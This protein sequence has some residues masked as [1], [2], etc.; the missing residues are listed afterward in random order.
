L[1]AEIAAS[2]T[3]R[4]TGGTR[5]SRAFVVGLALIALAGFSV[6]IGYALAGGGVR[7]SD[8]GGYYHVAAN[9][10]VDG[11]GFVN[12]WGGTPTGQHPPAWPILLALPSVAGFQS[13]LAHQV[14]AAIVGTVTVP[15]VGVAG[16][17][18]A[19][20]RVGLIAAG[21]TAVN[22]N[23]WVRERELLGQ[24]LV[25][26]LVAVTLVIA[27]RYW[28][29]PRA[30][31]LVAV[32]AMCG[33]L[34]LV[35][36]SLALLLAILIPLL[37]LR[38]PS[39]LSRAGRLK[40]LGAAL[41]VAILVLLPWVVRQ[42]VRF[43]R[44]TFLTTTFGLNLRVGTCPAGYYGDRIGSSDPGM[45]LP[46][47]DDGSDRCG[48]DP[49]LDTEPE[50]DDAYLSQAL[51]YMRENPGRVPIVTAARQGRMWG[52]FRPFQTSTF[53]Q[54]FGGGPL[55]VHHTG[56][57]FYW[58]LVPFAVAGAVQLRRSGVTLLPMVPFFLVAI[59]AAAIAF[60]TYRYRAPAEVPIV[61]LAA[62]GLDRLWTGAAH[63]RKAARNESTT[64][65]T[66]ASVMSV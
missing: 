52:V 48:Y 50:Q 59:A 66:S 12:P 61:I 60:G 64:S 34:A 24:T 23:F 63:G 46:L 21:V 29:A 49:A 13:L 3:Q 58:A 35:H 47:A 28:R 57:V 20:T 40:Q 41:S 39:G 8:D 32:G 2:E 17:A 7:A 19:G 42:T 26:P 51:S 15:L 33:L 36:A 53:E 27:Y 65:S 31:M 45:W 18:V 4:R 38:A 14:F 10:L 54:E 1:Q 11:A 30:T 22:P 43:E 37:A 6:R 62:A 44:P 56:V 16:R 25:F 55:G 5:S 9:L